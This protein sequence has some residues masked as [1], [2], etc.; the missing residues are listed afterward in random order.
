VS[1]SPLKCA[2]PIYVLLALLQR[3]SADGMLIYSKKCNEIEAFCSGLKTTKI[4]F[5]RG[6]SRT[7]LGELTSHDAS[8]DPLV[9]WGGEIPIPL[10]ITDRSFA[11][12]KILTPQLPSLSYYGCWSDISASSICSVMI[13][14]FSI[15]CQ[16]LAPTD[17]CWR[18]ANFTAKCNVA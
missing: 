4:V 14:K 11:Y 3:T 18:D 12:I 6:F 9:G 10:L 16:L 17:V 7:P 13:M 5:G 15:I 1:S 8:P 2:E